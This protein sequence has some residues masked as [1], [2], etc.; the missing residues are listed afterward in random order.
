MKINKLFYA[1]TLIL[2]LS[3][4]TKSI[5]FPVSTVVPA[6]NISAI[7]KI[8]NQKNFA[9]EIT[10]RNMASAARLDPP[11]NNYSVWIVTKEYGVKNIGQLNVEN[12]KKT[13]FKTVTAFDFNEVFITVEDR[14][15]LQYPIGAEV[16]RV[17]L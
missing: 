10:A 8:D 2:F 14:G 9:L 17:V 5:H 6:A 3:S 11:G 7:K 16:A 15:D 13:I 1:I 12:A 4:C